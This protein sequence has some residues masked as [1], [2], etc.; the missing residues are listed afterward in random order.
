MMA[1]M[2]TMDHV[3]LVDAAAHMAGAAA[4][5]DAAVGAVEA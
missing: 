4:L 3:L 5:L 1:H 2:P